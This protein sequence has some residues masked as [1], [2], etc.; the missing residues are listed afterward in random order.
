MVAIA[1][2]VSSR[3]GSFVGANAFTDYKR[4]EANVICGSSASAWKLARYLEVRANYYLPL[5]S[6][7]TV[8]SFDAIEFTNTVVQPRD[9]RVVTRTIDIIEEPMEA[10]Y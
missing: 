9:S 1:S 4:T 2:P 5:H 3:E 10:L 7:D 8:G 6:G